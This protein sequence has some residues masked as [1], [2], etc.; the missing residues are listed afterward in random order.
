MYLVDWWNHILLDDWGY[1]CYWIIGGIHGPFK[2]LRD[3]VIA[4]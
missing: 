1:I 4:G 3:T 2:D